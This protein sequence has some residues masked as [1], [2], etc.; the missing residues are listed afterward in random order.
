LLVLVGVQELLEL[1]GGQ[2]PDRQAAALVDRRAQLFQV[3]LV[4]LVVG[5]GVLAHVGS[6][7]P[8]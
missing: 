5:V 2:G 4:V 1:L 7:L 3:L 6:F 8:A